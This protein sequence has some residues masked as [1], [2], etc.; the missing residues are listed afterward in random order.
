VLSIGSEAWT[1]CKRDE[2]RCTAIEMNSLWEQ[3]TIDSFGLQNK[4]RHNERIKY[5]TN[6]WIYRK[7][8][9]SLQKTRSSNAPLN[10][11]FRSLPYQPK[12][13]R[14]LGRPYKR[15]HETITGHWADENVKITHVKTSVNWK[16]EILR[17]WLRVRLS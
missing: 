16:I 12:W 6:H 9:S 8:Q 7:L 14:S 11:L 17:V 3:L 10:N 5:T 4:F 1:I 15:W 2:S 13:R